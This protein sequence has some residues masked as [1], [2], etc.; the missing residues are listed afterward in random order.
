MNIDFLSDITDM[1]T[2]YSIYSEEGDERKIYLE[3]DSIMEC[4]YSGSSTVTQYPAES[5]INV[6]D[7]KYSNPDQ[8]HMK[9]VIMKN[10]TFG[11]GA[12]NLNFSL[13][14]EDKVSLIEKTRKQLNDLCRQ[15]VRVNIQTRNAGLR[16]SFTLSSFEINETPENYNLLEVDMVFDEVLLFGASGRVNRSPADNDTQDGGIVQ[17]LVADIKEWWSS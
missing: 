10:G 13:T 16:E 7:Y 4:S 9:G 6:T 15:M 2:T 12:L 5:G 3:F 1:L 17:T 11:I 8:I 14:G